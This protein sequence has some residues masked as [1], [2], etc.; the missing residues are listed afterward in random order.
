MTNSTNFSPDL[1]QF[2]PNNRSF[3]PDFLLFATKKSDF[4]PDPITIPK[5]KKAPVRMLFYYSPK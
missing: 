2:M 1:T 3:L 5:I 4:P